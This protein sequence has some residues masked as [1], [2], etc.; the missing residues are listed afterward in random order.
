MTNLEQR[1]VSFDILIENWR[2][3]KT[4]RQ[5]SI[6]AV[7][8]FINYQRK[9][10]LKKLYKNI[11]LNSLQRYQNELSVTYSKH[12]LQKIGLYRWKQC[13]SSSL[14]NRHFVQITN[15]FPTE[16]YLLI[17]QYFSRFF[18]LLKD[19]IRKQKAKRL[20]F[21]SNSALVSQAFQTLDMNRLL[22]KRWKKQNKRLNY[23]HAQSCLNK[24]FGKYNCYLLF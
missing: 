10:C 14:R 16:N 6:K 17:C 12:S 7:A 9:R 11:K 18:Q 22:H 15:I 2:L 23:E 5:A 4:E 3:R 13:Y 24:L 8:F 19:K 1:R 21:H 20:Y